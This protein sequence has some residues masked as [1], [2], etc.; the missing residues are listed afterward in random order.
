[1]ASRVHYGNNQV[2][3][4]LN[5]DGT[6]Y[7]YYPNGRIAVAVSSASDYQNSFYAFD[8]NSK[9][10]VLLAMDELAV[11]FATSSTRKSLDIDK[12]IIVLSKTGCVVS[13]NGGII[14]EWTWDRGSIN[15]GTAPTEN[16]RATLND[17][18]IFVL[19]DR[20]T[21][22]LEFSCDGVSLT[23]DL[24]AKVR[25]NDTYLDHCKREPGGR[26]L[27]MI[28]HKTLK[29]RQVLLSESFKAQR[30]KVK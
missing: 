18:L 22:G 26:L 13:S 24:G 25:R 19:L 29:E 11:G 23:L 28:E 20:K 30:N 3:V 1:M 4:D 16:I 6:G 27:P 7:V 15:S 8:N 2:A 10:T 9:S 21:L 17:N 12:C 14:H 5:D